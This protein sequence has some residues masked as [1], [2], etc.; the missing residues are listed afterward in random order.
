MRLI[1]S[2]YTAISANSGKIQS[3]AL[4]G[5]IGNK[6]DVRFAITRLTLVDKTSRRRGLART[7]VNTFYH[8]TEAQSFEQ[9]RRME[10]RMF[11]AYPSY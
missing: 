5:I 11:T 7:E 10:M 9:H 3:T 4:D 1:E 8:Y 6:Q 2:V